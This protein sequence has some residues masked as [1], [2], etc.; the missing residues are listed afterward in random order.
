MRL[1]TKKSESWPTTSAD[2]FSRLSAYDRA[3]DQT[4][5]EGGDGGGD[6]RLPF[7]PARWAALVREDAIQALIF[8]CGEAVRS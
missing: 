4:V 1:R 5:D 7:P 8:T 6:R 3:L 2:V